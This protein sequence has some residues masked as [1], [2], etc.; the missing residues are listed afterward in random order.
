MKL[1]KELLKEMILKEMGETKERHKPKYDKI[2]EILK[3]FHHESVAIMSGQNPMAQSPVGRKPEVIQMGNMRR[4]DNLEK[5]VG[6][7]GFEYMRIGGKFAGIFE[8]SVLIFDPRQPNSSK[9]AHRKFLNKIAQLNRDF[10]QWGFVGGRKFDDGIQPVMVFT[11]YQIDY[12]EKMFPNAYYISPEFEQTTEV[13][14]HDQVSPQ[15]DYSFDP[16]S[17]KRMSIPLKYNPRPKA[18]E[19]LPDEERE[20]RYQDRYYK[21]GYEI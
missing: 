6:A 15:G 18:Q 9:D 21:T 8:N 4:K 7:L 5:A 19:D 11:M 17:G 14:E 13:L 2:I 12:K 1:T 16:T 10:Q 3:G 20:P